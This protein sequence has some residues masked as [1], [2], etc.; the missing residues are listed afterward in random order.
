MITR[1]AMPEVESERRPTVGLAPHGF[2]APLR[3]R[4]SMAGEGGGDLARG[5]RAAD[6]G[7]GVVDGD[8][9]PAERP[10]LDQR[11]GALGFGELG[12]AGNG[13]AAVCRGPI[14]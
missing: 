5:V 1:P 10:L 3:G 7:V 11:P 13:T 14:R 8:D 2:P 6:V 9:Q 4:E 12:Q